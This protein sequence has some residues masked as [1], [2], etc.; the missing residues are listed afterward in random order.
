[1]ADRFVGGGAILG[2]L[3]YV[4]EIWKHSIFSTVRP[5]V[6]TNPSQQRSVSKILFEPEEFENTW[7]FSVDKKHF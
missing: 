1:M 2:R 4:R 5:T 3:Y 6:H 7:H